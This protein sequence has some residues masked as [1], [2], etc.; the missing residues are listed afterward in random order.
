MFNIYPMP[1][2][3]S[4][5][6]PL[7][8]KNFKLDPLS[9]SQY[10]FLVN[11]PYQ[12]FALACLGLS[13]T[14]EL[15]EELD[16]M[17]F[18]SLVHKCIYA[19]FVKEPSMPGPFTEKVTSKNRKA[20]VAMLNSISE[21]VFNQYSERSFSDLLW[22]QRWLNLI[23]EFIDWEIQRQEDYTPYKHE[24][25]LQKNIDTTRSLIGRADRID[26]SATAYAIVDYKT[27]QT[28]SKKNVLAGEQV[29]LPL[30]AL[31]HE[32]CNQVEYVAIGKDNK[33]RTESVLKDDQLARLV[34]EHRNRISEYANTLNDAKKI[35]FYDSLIYSEFQKNINKR[36][37]PMIQMMRNAALTAF[38][39]WDKK[40][41]K[42][43]Y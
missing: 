36:K 37:I 9:I 12:F 4:Q 35:G 29:Q 7:F 33:V 3:S 1:I 31:L 8:S 6:S 11:C 24:A 21:H 27:G 15:S 39:L 25:L 13:K 17:D 34:D 22:L 42:V 16:K 23:P 28:P 32:N 26:K 14:N 5:P 41:D 43:K 20:A 10:Q 19:F 38:E 2:K 40:T 18:G 30:Y